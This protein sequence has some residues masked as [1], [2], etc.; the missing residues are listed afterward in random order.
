MVWQAN[1]LRLLVYQEQH[2][3]R[4]S[5]NLREADSCRAFHSEDSNAADDASDLDWSTNRQKL[6]SSVCSLEF[7]HR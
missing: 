7:Q 4:W 6:Q 2:E 3:D 1:T 5:H